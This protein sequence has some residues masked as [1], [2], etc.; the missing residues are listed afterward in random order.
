MGM[1]LG[2][3]EGRGGPELPATGKQDD[4]FQ[5]FQRAGAAAVLVVDHAIDMIRVSKIDQFGA[6]LEV[7]VIP[8]AEAQ[9]CRS[10]GLGLVQLLQVQQP[11]VPRVEG[12]ALVE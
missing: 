2:K 10:A 7:A 3:K 6:A 12:K 4:V 5:K 9:A 8:A 1:G 11:E